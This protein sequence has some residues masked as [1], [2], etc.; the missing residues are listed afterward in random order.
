MSSKNSMNKEE[1]VVIRCSSCG[2]NNRVNTS[3][4][5]ES[6]KP[7]CGKCQQTLQTTVTT[8]VILTDDNFST[9]VEQSKLPV[10]LDL[11][12]PWCGPCKMLTPVIEQ[13][14]SELAGKV[15]VAKL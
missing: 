9:E 6:V 1:S 14:A 13:L 3:K 5:V 15:K 10:L 7:I 4:L 11:W 2:A 8:P 12:A